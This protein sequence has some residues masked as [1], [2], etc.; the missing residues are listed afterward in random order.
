MSGGGGGGQTTTQEIPG[1]LKPLAKAYTN[2]AIGISNQPWQAYGGDRFAELN[3]TQNLGLG[4]IQDRALSGS[5]TMTNAEN[6]L[7]KFIQGGNTNPFLDQMVNKAQGSVATNFNN[8]VKPQ[9]E[10]AMRGSGSFGNSGFEQTMQGQQKAAGQQMSDI[11][12]QMYGGAYNQDQSNRMQ[13]IGMAP[14]FGNAAYQD[15]NE[16]MKAGQIQQ[17]HGQR[18][19][20]FGYQQWS[21]AQNKPYKDLASMAGVFGSNLG[22]KTTTTGGGK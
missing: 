17:D 8:M 21:D 4:K 5:Q 9:T 12:T 19:L 14:T 11:A 18:N 20:D 13:A 3:Q 10:A 22:G 15:A 1:E 6:G 2:K 7:N 16:L